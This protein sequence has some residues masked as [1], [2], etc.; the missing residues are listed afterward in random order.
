MLEGALAPNQREQAGGNI[1]FIKDSVQ[2]YYEDIH[3]LLMNFHTKVSNKDF[4]KT[5]ESL[6]MHFERQTGTPVDS[7]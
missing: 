3:E 7:R 6:L 4:P 1:N 5:V 2:G